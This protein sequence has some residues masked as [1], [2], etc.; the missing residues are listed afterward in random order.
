MLGSA[1][2]SSPFHDNEKALFPMVHVFIE[3]QDAHD[4]RPGGDAPVQLHLAACLRA[5]VENLQRRERG[6][7]EEGGTMRCVNA[8][9]WNRSVNAL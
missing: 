5:V 8:A 7:G 2:S 9:G 3:A 6:R 4:V 1:V